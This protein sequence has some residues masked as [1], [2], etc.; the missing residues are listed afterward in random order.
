MNKEEKIGNFFTVVMLV[1][2]FTLVNPAMAWDKSKNVSVVDNYI[3]PKMGNLYPADYPNQ[4]FSTL[5][6]SSLSASTLANK[7]TLFFFAN[8]PGLLNSTQKSIINSW[9]YDGGKLIIWD[10]EEPQGIPGGWDYTWLPY[11]FSTS[12]PGAQ[13]AYGK[14]LWVIE[15]NELSSN[16][17]GSPYFINTTILNNNTDAVGDA[18]VFTTYSSSWCVDMKAKNML[19]VEGPVHTYAFY[20]NGLI[21]YSGL[22]WDSAGTWSGWSVT[23]HPGIWLK[24][25]FKQELDV[26]GGLQCGVIQEGSPNLG[27]IKTADKT[28]YNIS[29][30]INFTIIVTNTGTLTAYG[31]NLTDIPPNEISISGPTT[32]A[33]GDLSAGAST[34][35]NI[36]AIAISPKHN[37][38]NI[39]NAAGR[40]SQNNI[41]AGSGNVTFSIDTVPPVIIGNTPTGSNVPET[42]QI[43]VTFNEAMN[44]TSVE[45]AFLISPPAAGS[46]SWS[47]N[48]MMYTPDPNLPSDTLYDVTIGTGAKDLAGNNLVSPYNW[49][50]STASAA[51]ITPRIRSSTAARRRFPIAAA[52]ALYSSQQRQEAASSA[53]LTETASHHAAVRKAIAVLLREA[54]PSM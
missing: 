46:F 28:S 1:L 38:I 22:D 14:G 26:S 21:I 25:L 48:I 43:T 15:N 39:A 19:N 11:P 27:V 50:F 35:V 37:L 4:T 52:R 16:I 10:S 49:Q 7:D 45:S 17:S 36:N 18:N 51:D 5:A 53:S 41:T 33:L 6:P 31:V 47:G 8:N 32:F 42:A 3:S 29:E 54:T 44:N 30:A 12:V 34:T 24:K 20:G 23:N 2:V 13:G 9:I 40:D